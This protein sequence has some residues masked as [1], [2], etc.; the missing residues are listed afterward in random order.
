MIRLIF[1]PF[2]SQAGLKASVIYSSSHARVW[3]G[4]PIGWNFFFSPLAL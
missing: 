1:D 4:L 2:S 3:F